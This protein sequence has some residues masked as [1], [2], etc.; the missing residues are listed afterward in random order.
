MG[1]EFLLLREEG[2]T[3]CRKNSVLRRVKLKVKLLISPDLGLYISEGM[4]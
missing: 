4:I 1:K 2:T 3:S